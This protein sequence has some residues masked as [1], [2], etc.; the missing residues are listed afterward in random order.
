MATQ[1]TTT[2]SPLEEHLSSKSPAERKRLQEWT[3]S[4]KDLDDEAL[5]SGVARARAQ[6][7][8]EGRL[9]P[10]EATA[11]TPS[12]SSLMRS[13]AEWEASQED[14]EADVWAEAFKKDAAQQSAQAKSKKGSR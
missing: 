11:K 5:V 12:S 8:T 3:T 7:E 10:P 13:Q 9:P 4:Y 14:W 1:N 2:T 6:M